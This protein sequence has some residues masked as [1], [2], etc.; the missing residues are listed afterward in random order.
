[1]RIR[2][3]G[4]FLASFVLLP[5][6][7][8]AGTISGEFRALPDKAGQTAE[9]TRLMLAPPIP[10]A[11]FTHT[12]GKDL[13]SRRYSMQIPGEGT[14]RS[15]S[16]YI[17]YRLKNSDGEIVAQRKANAIFIPLSF[18]EQGTVL[19]LCANDGRLHNCDKPD[20]IYPLP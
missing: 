17:E 4:L 1:M 9:I 20:Q 8:L 16:I 3:A 14:Y 11:R 15:N 12:K 5:N 7:S 13:S 18:T 2:L 19:N 10:E 6:P